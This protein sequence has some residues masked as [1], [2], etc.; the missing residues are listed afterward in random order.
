MDQG[1]GNP[2]ALLPVP[3][4]VWDRALVVGDAGMK[5]VGLSNEPL[6]VWKA[7][8]DLAEIIGQAVGPT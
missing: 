4:I 3:T 7:C 8:L 2:P 1:G 6:D 5:L